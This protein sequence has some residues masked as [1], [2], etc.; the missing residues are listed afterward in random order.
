MNNPNYIDL[1][2]NSLENNNNQ[3]LETQTSS[4]RKEEVNILE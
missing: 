1:I 4:K 3:E 2:N